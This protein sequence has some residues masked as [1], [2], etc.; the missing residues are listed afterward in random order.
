MEPRHSPIKLRK[1]LPQS[2]A[3]KLIPESMARKYKAIPVELN[4][5]VLRVAMADTSDIFALEAMEIQ[6][7]S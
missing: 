7:M 6:C 5:N 4:G 1:Y 2:D 3:L